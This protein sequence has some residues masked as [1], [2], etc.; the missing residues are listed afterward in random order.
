MVKLCEDNCPI[1]AEQKPE[2]KE[3]KCEITPDI[4]VGSEEDANDEDD[5]ASEL[6]CD[7][8]ST[9]ETEL[10]IPSYF[11]MS[12]DQ[13]EEIFQ[14]L[15]D[16]RTHYVSSH[17]YFNGYVKCCSKRFKTRG[18]IVDHIQW[19]QNPNAFM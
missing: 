11:D 3:I 19:H 17:N 5:S 13:C 18:H 16:A 4:F 15:V 14:S 1:S 8:P 10:I 9:K 7:E 12:C 2:T 6:S